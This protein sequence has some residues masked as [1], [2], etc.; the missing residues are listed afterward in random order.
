M[1]NELTHI[2]T[3]AKGE[4]APYQMDVTGLHYAVMPSQRNPGE[5]I[6]LCF[7]AKTH[8]PHLFGEQYQNYLRAQAQSLLYDWVFDI[9]MQTL[10]QSSSWKNDPSDFWLDLLVKPVSP[11]H[12]QNPPFQ[13]AIGHGLV[14][15]TRHSDV[16]LVSIGSVHHREDVSR[17]KMKPG[18]L[19]ESYC[20]KYDIPVFLKDH[21]HYISPDPI[22][23]EMFESVKDARPI[24]SVLEIGAAT[25]ILGSA[26]RKREVKDYTHLDINK[27]VCDHLRKHF[28]DQLVVEKDA[29]EY[30]P[31][32]KRDI[33]SIGL[34]YELLPSYL[35]KK[36]KEL[37]ASC[38]ILLI[39]SGCPGFFEFEHNWIMGK[40]MEQWPWFS[41]KQT[42]QE[43]FPHAIE[44][45]FGY[46]TGIIASHTPLNN[47][48]KAMK[49]RGIG[50]ITYDRIELNK[51]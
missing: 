38:D 12:P 9:T 26:A 18:G 3:I 31:E 32:R 24:D 14:D 22:T 28:P 49:G 19:M 1:D 36:G 11:L 5:V 16:Q 13:Q 44:T 40:E 17:G 51:R 20:E 23:V 45:L 34:Q 42:V 10:A 27:C 33:I 8:N 46:Q 35:E 50:P 37:A 39:Q 25:G 29:F 7:D 30:S 21:G 48:K 4:L 2:A 41:K 43:Y 15:I 47:I 6:S